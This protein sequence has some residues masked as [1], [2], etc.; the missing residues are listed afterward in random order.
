MK[1]LG[2][3]TGCEPNRKGGRSLKAKPKSFIIHRKMSKILKMLTEK[4]K[5]S[6][7]CSWLQCLPVLS[8]NLVSRSLHPELRSTAYGVSLIFDVHSRKAGSLMPLQKKS[9]SG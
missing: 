8:P 1:V 9:V 5:A 6:L 2:T 4:D 3:G 7:I